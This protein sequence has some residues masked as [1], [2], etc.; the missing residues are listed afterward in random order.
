MLGILQRKGKRAPCLCSNVS[1]PGQ[2][3][4][5]KECERSMGIQRD[6]KEKCREKRVVNIKIN[7]DNKLWK[8]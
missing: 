1:R 5:A 8:S 2:H 3:L 4:R 7:R 6:K